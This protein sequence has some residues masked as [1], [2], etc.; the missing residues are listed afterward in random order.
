MHTR[1]KSNSLQVIN[2]CS[3]VSAITNAVLAALKII[4]GILGFSFALLTDGIHSLSDV[5]IDGL[6]AFSAKLGH[7]P[8][9]AEHPYG[10]RR[11]ETLGTILVSLIILAVGLGILVENGL[12]LLHGTLAQKPHI[13][14][15]VV[16]IVSVIT[17]ETLYRY[18][19]K[20]ACQ[21]KSDLLRSSAWH[22]RSDALTSIIVL[23]SAAFSWFGWKQ[24]DAIA[25]I[26][27][28]LFIIKLGAQ[29]AWNSLRELVDSGVSNDELQTIEG[30]MAETPGVLSVHQLRTRL[31]S[32]KILLD[33]HVQVAPTI[34]VSEGHYV[35]V[36]VHQSIRK[37][38]PN[39]LDA[40]IHIDVEDDDDNHY[41]SPP[42]LSRSDIL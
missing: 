28:S 26:L 15:F 34:S 32:G 36:M 31:H 12:R 5:L 16:A 8:P 18:M 7:Q 24:V 19:H 23:I 29:Y 27:I 21:I 42:L 40:T 14:V 3:L 17:N 2:R 11:I 33:A 25:A 6:V 20:K 10:H 38:L 13:I 39:I 41:D 30:A 22:N 4:F 1:H 35:G 9:D 37:I